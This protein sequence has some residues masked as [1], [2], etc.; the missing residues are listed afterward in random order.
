MSGKW[1]KNSD[2][3]RMFS[4]GKTFIS[5][6]NNLV[7]SSRKMQMEFWQVENVGYNCWYK[8]LELIC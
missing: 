8:L 1:Q 3:R 4:K 7:K 5:K 6:S 2:I